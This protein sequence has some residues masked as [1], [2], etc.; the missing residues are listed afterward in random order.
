MVKADCVE[1][2]MNI[3]EGTRCA[4]DYQ[5]LRDSIEQLLFCAWKGIA[6]AIT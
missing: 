1:M 2:R 6:K 5:L 4:K 3:L